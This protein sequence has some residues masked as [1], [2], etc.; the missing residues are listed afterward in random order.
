MLM[1]L[2]KHIK[3]VWYLSHWARADT[4]LKAVSTQVTWSKPGS[5]L[6]LLSNRS[7]VTFPFTECQPLQSNPVSARVS[8]PPGNSWK[9]KFKVLESLGIYLWFSLTN[10]SFMCGTRRVNKCMKYCCCVLTE[11]FLCNLW[12]TFC[13]ELFCH[14]VYM[15]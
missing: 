4:C 10:M 15:E 5:S 6:M 13:D 12:W 1:V 2:M 9:L 7:T 3:V 8:T 14:T 11:Q